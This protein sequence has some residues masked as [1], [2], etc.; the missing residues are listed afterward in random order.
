[1]MLNRYTLLKNPKVVGAIIADIGVGF[2]VNAL[3]ALSHKEMD[4]I[5][6]IDIIIG[7]LLITEGN[8]SKYKE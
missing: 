6:F 3:F 7:M 1:M 8:I 5:N 4:L 2:L